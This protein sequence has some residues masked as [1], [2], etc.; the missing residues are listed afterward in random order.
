V[1]IRRAKDLYYIGEFGATAITALAPGA[2]ESDPLSV[3]GRLSFSYPPGH[4]HPTPGF[5]VRPTPGDPQAV[6][7]V[8]NIGSQFN[9]ALSTDPVTISGFGL[10]PTALDGDSLYMVTIR[11]TGGTALASNPRQVATGIRNV[12]G[13]A[14]DPASGDLYFADNAIDEDVVTTTSEPPQADELN[15]IPAADL[16]VNVLRFGYPDCYRAY[17]TNDLVE[18]AP[19]TCG[20]VTQS[21]FQFQPIPNTASGSRSEGPAEIAFSPALFP[22]P[23]QGGIF[24]G[25]SGGVGPGGVNNQNA[26]VFV[27]SLFG[28]ALHFVASG[29]PGIG[30]ILGVHSTQDSLFLADWNGGTIYQVT[31]LPVPETGSFPLVGFGLL[32]LGLFYRARRW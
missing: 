31:A 14:F 20:G 4:G 30:N 21:L 24:A 12:Y 18:T 23:F 6:D 29:T 13:M 3:A 22:A 10:G 11:E 5:A 8:F 27:D 32:A 9:N 15:R 26:V 7:L 17:R 28:Q 25:F 1:Q 2:A 16:G 19:G